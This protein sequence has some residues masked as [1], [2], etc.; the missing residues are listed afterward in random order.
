[1]SEK[2]L[3][4]ALLSAVCVALAPAAILADPI[5]KSGSTSLCHALRFPARDEHRRPEPGHGHAP[6]GSWHDREPQGR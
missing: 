1:M 4:L 2:T 5:E 3:K 6:R